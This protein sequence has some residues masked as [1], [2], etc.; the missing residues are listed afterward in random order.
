MLPG[1]PHAVYVCRASEWGLA[2]VLRTLVS[3]GDV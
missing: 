2:C 3:I 1:L